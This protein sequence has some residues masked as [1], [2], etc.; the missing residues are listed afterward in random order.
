MA[1]FIN[2]KNKTRALHLSGD[3]WLEWQGFKSDREW[4]GFTLEVWV[5]LKMTAHLH[6]L[7]T[8]DFALTLGR[9]QVGFHPGEGHSHVQ[10][11]CVVEPN[12]WTHLAIVLDENRKL[13]I[14]INGKLAS[15]SQLSEDHQFKASPL[16]V[17]ILPE[18]HHSWDDMNLEVDAAQEAINA[19]KGDGDASLN[20]FIGALNIWSLARKKHEIMV[21]MYVEPPD[22]ATGLVLSQWMEEDSDL[23]GYHHHGHAELEETPPPVMNDLE[24]AEFTVPDPTTIKGRLKD[25]SSDF[26]QW[27]ENSIYRRFKDQADEIPLICT[28]YIGDINPDNNNEQKNIEQDGTKMVLN[29]NS[30][31]IMMSR[32]E[33][34]DWRACFEDFDSTTL[35]GK[36]ATTEHDSDAEIY[37]IHL[38][39]E[40]R[41]YFAYSGDYGGL[42][43]A[44]LVKMTHV[45]TGEVKY[46]VWDP[47]IEVGTRPTTGGTGA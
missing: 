44:L 24:L 45:V 34:E 3:A 12:V 33:S 5:K 26:A 22:Y 13:N 43:Y 1:G 31:L 29:R 42:S 37:D 38:C 20:G 11:P 17:G 18:D 39:D 7:I 40:N 14:Y 46:V 10:A 27:D 30:N 6:G 35:Y 47:T 25:M 15:E 23:T 36:G 2:L 19:L 16:M 8:A 28:R 41:A 9:D 32:S 4:K 21:D